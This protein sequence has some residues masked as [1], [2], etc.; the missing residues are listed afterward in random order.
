MA[1][2]LASIVSEV[3]NLAFLGDDDGGRFFSPY[4]PRQRFARATLATASLLLGKCYFAYDDRDL[5]EI[6]T[7]WLGPERC[8]TPP[9]IEHEQ[10]SRLFEN[11]SIVVMRHGPVLALFDFGPFGPGGAG[12]SHS[13]SLSFVVSVGDREVLI[14]SGTFS[15][16]HPEFRSHF[17][18]SVAHNTIVVDGNDQGVAAG[19]FRW[20]EK[21]EVQL[22]ESAD[23]RATAICSY[24]GFSHARS[25]DFAN[26]EFTIKDEVAGPIG[27]HDIEQFWHFAVEPRELSRG[28]WA[29]GDTAEF[30]AEDGVVEP[31]W[32]SRCFGSKEAAWVIVV[33]RRASLPLTLT[34]RLRISSLSA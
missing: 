1:E 28:T 31:A 12:H 9:A 3:G 4:G 20:S 22:L 13:D 10:C 30:A 24:Q 25:V 23:T 17:R 33:R 32:R 26:G 19:P 2:F 27:E 16:M 15:Y 11:T 34:A 29:V 14:D 6:A 21:P 5:A 8:A 18:G 7:W